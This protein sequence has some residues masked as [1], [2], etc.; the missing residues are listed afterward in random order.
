MDKN[1]GRKLDGRYEITEL[2]GVGGMADVYKATDIL[3]DRTVAVKILKNEFADNEDFVRRFRN[4][5]KAIAVLSHPNI[6]KIYDVGFTDKIQ[7]IVM[8]YIDGITLKEFIEQQGVLKWKD[9]VHFIVQILRALQHAHDRGIV[10]RDIKPQNIMLFPDGTIK[11]MDFGIARFAR[12]EGKTISDKA[13]GSVHYISP[14]QAR[15]DIT[16]EKSDIYS[17]GVMMYEM[18]T[19]VKP[20]DADNP[21]TV[22]LMHMQNEPK[23]PREINDSI[24]EG[25]EEIVIRAMQK[26]ASKRYQSASEMI[27]DIEEFKKNPSIVFEYKYLSEKTQYYNAGA[28]SKA[29]A[30]AAYEANSAEKGAHYAAE[31][32]EER[33]VKTKTKVRKKDMPDPD[34][35]YEDYDDYEDEEAVSKSS[36]FVVILTA[37]AAGILIIVVA[38]I[39]IAF[40]RTLGS[41][42]TQI[43]QMPNIVGCSYQ[44]VETY[45]ASSFDVTVESQE[46]S[47]EYP[48][49]A[50]ISQNPEEGRD[51]LVGKAVVKVTVSKGPRMVTIPNVYD[52]DSDYAQNVLRDNNGFN[53]IIMTVFD[54]EVDKGTVIMTDPARNEQAEYGS[55]VYLYVS[56]GPEEQDVIVPSVVGYDIE[57]AKT[58]LGDKFTIQVMSIDSSEPEGT[59][60]E[61]SLPAVGDDG[62]SNIVPI[63]STII[64]TVSTGVAPE[65]EAVITFKIPSGVTGGSAVFNCYYNGN[66]VGTETID[67]VAYASTV[68]VTVKGSG[69]QKIMLE[70]VNTDTNE[71]DTIG[72][73]TVDYDEGTVTETDFQKSVFRS[74]FTEEEETTVTLDETGNLDNG[75]TNI[76]EEDEVIDL[77][78]E[79]FWNNL[80]NGY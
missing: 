69:I 54:D 53:V 3:E 56:R 38:F 75:E 11:V 8:E 73:Y 20:F 57:A 78:D 19:G 59:V 43:A 9:T 47:S 70:A 33:K 5:S 41:E 29:A 27:K 26:E 80:L 30:A 64:L 23:M 1:I 52:L 71:S 45:Y 13:I 68:S 4:E 39:A 61:Q 37:I 17:V 21:V 31:K 55:T 7:F 72:E 24:P 35:E 6:V 65:A 48:E 58:L 40:I 34:D 66:I 2:I 60:V 67:N 28:V 36:Y 76:D 25:L 12:E 77:D 46:Y 32:S 18:L 63:N 50:I 62:S 42:K 49:G 44:Q 51:Y 16:D 15:G 74:L 79:D 14:E 10:H 22:A